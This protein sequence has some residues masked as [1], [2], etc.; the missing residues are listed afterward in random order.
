MNEFEE[1]LR[2]ALQHDAG[3]ATPE[4]EVWS[5]VQARAR[6]RR[7][8]RVL[9]RAATG[10]VAAAAVTAVVVIGLGR[11]GRGNRVIAGKP[12]AGGERLVVQLD[13]SVE[14]RSPSTGRLERTL[15]NAHRASSA[16]AGV[17][18]SPDG[19]SV[20]YTRTRA[21]NRCGATPRS[22]VVVVDVSSGRTRAVVDNADG[23]RLSRD[24]AL[25]GYATVDQPDPCGPYRAVDVRNLRTGVV[26]HWSAGADATQVTPLD[27]SSHSQR[28]LV[29]VA[30]V[31][32]TRPDLEVVSPTSA[33]APAL[34]IGSRDPITAAAWLG[35]TG[36]VAAAVQSDT[37]TRVVGLDLDG[38]PVRYLF[39]LNERSIVSLDVDP[40]GQQVVVLTRPLRGSNQR[41]E[42]WRWSPG[43][44]AH[45]LGASIRA[46]SGAVAWLP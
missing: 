38:N 23:P 22:E 20:Y 37:G 32:S 28:L 4:P 27:W 11:G 36:L 18:A 30:H 2:D 16:A 8:R 33:A 31:D 6:Q 19:R 34:V 25:L 42:L 12:P 3:S 9:A 35:D 29:L 17:T 24:G 1:L 40:S 7:R 14:L 45:R 43:P 41:T 46:V 13:G 44:S 26:T 5:A 15:V 21:G 10:L 39:D